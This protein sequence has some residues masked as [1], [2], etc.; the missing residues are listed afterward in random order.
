MVDKSP[1][2]VSNYIN[3]HA[4]NF[5][6]FTK[7]DNRYFINKVECNSNYDTDPDFT[8]PKSPCLV[9]LK[10]SSKKNLNDTVKDLVPEYDHL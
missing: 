9:N 3:Y 2:V 10:R 6:R 1:S 4:P 8:T 5:N 7:R